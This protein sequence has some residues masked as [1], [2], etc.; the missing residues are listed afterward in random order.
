MGDLDPAQAAS[1]DDLAKCLRQLHL[2]A[3]S[4]SFRLLEKRT[5][6]KSGLLPGT[7]IERVPLRRT[8]L[9]EVLQG[10]TFPRKGFLLT[11]V[12]AC[13]VDLRT[14]PRW[15]QAWDR[16]ADQD[17]YQDREMAIGQLQRELDELR[18]QLADAQHR[19]EVAQAQADRVTAEMRAIVR[20]EGSERPIYTLRDLNKQTVRIMSEIEKSGMPTFITSNGRFVAII[21]SLESGQVETRVLAELAREIGRREGS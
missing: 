10:Q 17:Q 11:F 19:A 9:S 18:R 13:G 21:M 4:P 14:D 16:L 5:E 6:H 2:R 1:L 20:A 7:K 12:E 3:D 15:E 8:T